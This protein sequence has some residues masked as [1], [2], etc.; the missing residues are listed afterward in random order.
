MQGAD[1][2]AVDPALETASAD[3][4]SAHYDGP[5]VPIPYADPSTAPY[6]SWFTLKAEYMD[7]QE[8]VKLQREDPDGKRKAGGY[9]LAEYWEQ[10][11]ASAVYGLG[12][13]VLRGL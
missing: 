4:L 1:A 3:P 5:Y 11:I 8:G 10:E 12:V 2:D 7:S 6:A 13:D 9:I